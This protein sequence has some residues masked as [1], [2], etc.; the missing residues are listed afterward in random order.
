[1][2]AR[3]KV[4]ITYMGGKQR[5]AGWIEK[6]IPYDL[7]H[8]VEPY[9]GGGAV[10]FYIRQ[11]TNRKFHSYVLNDKFDMIVNFYKVLQDEKKFKELHRLLVLTPYSR[12]I[13]LEARERIKKND[14]KNDIDKA[15]LYYCLVCFSYLNKGCAFSIVSKRNQVT[16]YNSKVD[17]FPEFHNNIKKAYVDSRCALEIIEKQDNE[18]VFFYLDPPY[19]KTYQDGYKNKYSVED[20]KELV[21]KLFFI[22]GKFILSYYDIFDLAYPNEWHKETLKTKSSMGNIDVKNLKNSDEREETILMNFKPSVMKQRRFDFL[23]SE[24][25]NI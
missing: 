10:F 18:D 13:Y 8:Y 19:P 25:S 1:M 9:F 11:C 21:E 14:F 15:Y 16:Q 23:E 6:F 3:L 17:A 22:K 7:K 5:I 2:S 4:P 20:F 24:W 12:K